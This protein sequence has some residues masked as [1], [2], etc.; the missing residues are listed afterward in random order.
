MAYDVAGLRLMT[1][2]SDLP[3]T[4]SVSSTPGIRVQQ[5]W[6]YLTADAAATVDAAGYFNSAA[7][8]LGKGDL[9]FITSV[10]GGTPVLKAKIVT[11]SDGV[12]AVTVALQTTT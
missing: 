12:G 8:L 3:A 7:P 1:L 6:T 9:I 4:G 2:G 5:V 10:I 11:V